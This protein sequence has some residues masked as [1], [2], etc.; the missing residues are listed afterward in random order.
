MKAIAAAA[1][2]ALLFTVMN[3]QGAE[4][5][6]LESRPTFK[7]KDWT[8]ELSPDGNI[9]HLF[10]SYDE[11]EELKILTRLAKEMEEKRR[12]EHGIEP[13]EWKIIYCLSKETDMI[14]RDVDGTRYRETAGMGRG[15]LEWALLNE[16]QYYDAAYGYSRGNVKI[17]PTDRVM[18]E[19]ML[20]E[21]TNVTFFW[22]R[23]WPDLGIGID[24][25]NYDSV[26]G[27]YYPGETRPWA[28]GGTGGGGGWCDHLG[29]TSVQFAPGREVGGSLGDLGKITLHEWLHQID[30]QKG[31]KCGYIGLPGQYS[32]G[33]YH[34]GSHLFWMWHMLPSRMF[35]TM[36]MQAPLMSPPNKPQDRYSG[37]I[38]N[39]LLLGEFDLPAEIKSSNAGIPHP[40]ALDVEAIEVK[41]TMPS[42]EIEE[43]GKKWLLL[44]AEWNR[45]NVAM[46]KMFHSPHEDAFVYAHTYVH[47]PDEREAILWVGG[48]E[49]F[50]AY[51]NGRQV[52]K[53]WRGVAEDEAS[54]KVVL[55]KGWNRLLIKKLD[56]EDKSWNLFARFT[57]PKHIV[58]ED[59][60][61]TTDKPENDIVSTSQ[62]EPALPVDVKH[63]KWEWP[64][65]ND[66]F[67]SLPI[68]TEE[69][70]DEILGVKGVRILG[71]PGTLNGRGLEW[72]ERRYTLID[73]STVDKPENILSRVLP[74]NA[75]KTTLENDVLLNNVLNMSREGADGRSYE[76]MAIIRYRKPD[77][78]HGDLVFVR[79]DM[80]EPFMDLAK[81]AGGPANPADN[82]LGF[83]CRDSKTF[84][85]F[86]T[87]LGEQ[88]PINELDMLAV[89]DENAALTAAP[90]EPRVLRGT[91]VNVNVKLVAPRVDVAKLTA[92]EFGTDKTMELGIKMT[93][94]GV[95]YS[96]FPVDTDRPAGLITYIIE[97]AYEKDGET[98]TLSKPVPINLVDAVGIEIRVDGPELLQVPKHKVTI[99]VTNNLDRAVAGTLRPKLPKGFRIKP[100]SHKINLSALDESQTFTFDMNISTRAPEGW[101]TLAAETKVP[102]EATC[103]GELD[104]YKSFSDTLVNEDFENGVGGDFGYTNAHYQVRLNRQ[105][106]KFGRQCLEVFD[107]GG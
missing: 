39:W 67:G 12:K 77:G 20:G 55:N 61:F 11:G 9:Q 4:R 7:W 60:K 43:A 80:I 74:W 45:N 31:W 36:R 88:L 63:Y 68:L 78:A 107:R 15:D 50:A 79:A 2:F 71:A 26:V 22:P 97:A 66:W 10:L 25:H 3:C 70:L 44:K 19:P 58:F 83:I 8:A 30:G 32:P 98:H 38:Q 52:L 90:S 57:D 76:S 81:S 5:K 34:H 82:V 17:V 54:R 103:R 16:Q 72:K 93:E 84:L 13:N 89:K 94:V 86:D 46:R 99:K 41:E 96:S 14:F 40:K 101:L 27:H 56:Q 51:L 65:N 48:H 100:R 105:A 18:E 85:V 69:H 106:A 37:F 1:C 24:S 91:P 75:A 95:L 64:Y 47:S 42:N 104:V 33:N 92:R 6:P 23:G 62:A 87:D 53:C 73:V 28:R 35:Q 49:P 102:G 29:H 21:Y 59:L